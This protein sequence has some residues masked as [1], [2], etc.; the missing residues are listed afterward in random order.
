MNAFHAGHC[1]GGG[2]GTTQLQLVLHLPTC[3]FAA[4]SSHDSPVS[5]I[6]FPHTDEDAHAATLHVS[7]VFAGFVPVQLLSGAIDPSFFLQTTETVRVPHPHDTL[8]APGVPDCQ[9]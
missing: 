3:P 1:T 6:L 7:I 4:P 5:M 9:L 2:G 8:Q